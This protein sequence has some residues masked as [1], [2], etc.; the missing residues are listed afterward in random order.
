M[1]ISLLSFPGESNTQIEKV[2][3]ITEELKTYFQKPRNNL[4]LRHAARQILRITQTCFSVS[5][6]T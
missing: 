3:I 6:G 2:P 5:C 1:Q 4:I